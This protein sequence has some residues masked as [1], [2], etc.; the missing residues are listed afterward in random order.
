M[1]P[2]GLAR[3]YLSH[4]AFDDAVARLG[5][6]VLTAARVLSLAQDLSK[7]LARFEFI[8]IHDP[9][10]SGRIAAGH[11]PTP[12][13]TTAACCDLATAIAPPG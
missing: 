7:K 13:S 10:V 4:P 11:E 3:E 8:R 2:P 6:W 12:T 9:E 5:T 1:R